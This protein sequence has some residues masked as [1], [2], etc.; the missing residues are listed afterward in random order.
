MKAGCT[1]GNTLFAE[2]NAALACSEILVVV[3]DCISRLKVIRFSPNSA[4]T[5]DIPCPPETIF[6]F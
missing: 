3:F 4:T 2:S 6:V 5:F 1:C